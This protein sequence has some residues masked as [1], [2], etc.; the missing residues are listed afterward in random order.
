MA[1]TYPWIGTKT[2]QGRLCNLSGAAPLV[3]SGWLHIQDG[4]D[5]NC[6]SFDVVAT[7]HE[8]EELIRPN[9]KDALLWVELHVEHSKY[10]K[11]LLQITTM[12][13][14]GLTFHNHVV[15]VDF[16]GLTNEGLEQFVDQAL[17]GGPCIL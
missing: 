9:S 15:D 3:Y 12:I 8:P 13:P 1:G 10:V 4:L 6:V 2:V 7:D 17:V 11:R 5:F 16:H 14:I